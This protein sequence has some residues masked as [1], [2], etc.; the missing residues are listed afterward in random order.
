MKLKK[1]LFIGCILSLSANTLFSQNTL[2]VYPAPA[3]GVEMKN[4]FTVKVRET[5]KE[6]KTVDTY[7]VKVDEVRGTR[8]HVEKASLG[9]VDFEGEVEVSVT[10]NNGDIET[11]KVRP[12]SYDILPA[13]D[14]NTM[15]F[16]LDRPVNL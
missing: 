1:L 7:S 11:G 2:T 12:L 5:G 8:H 4:D 14:N 9:Y 10:F 3:T 13:I 15:T 16:T 6:W